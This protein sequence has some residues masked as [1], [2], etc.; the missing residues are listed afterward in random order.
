MLMVGQ[1]KDEDRNKLRQALPP[2]V[3]ATL[4]KAES[5]ERAR[6]DARYDVEPVQKDGVVTFEEAQVVLEKEKRVA[7]NLGVRRV[8]VRRVDVTTL[9]RSIRE[10][11]LETSDPRLWQAITLLQRWPSV[12]ATHELVA[13]L[14][15]AAYLHAS[16]RNVKRVLA[17]RIPPV[18]HR[19]LYV[20]SRRALTY[21]VRMLAAL[22]AVGVA[23]LTCLMRGSIGDIVAAGAADLSLRMVDE[24]CAIAAANGFAPRLPSVERIRSGVTAAGSPMSAS[25]LKDLERVGKYQG[26][27]SV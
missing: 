6:T 10:R 20:S 8:D 21:W 17:M 26:M 7:G 9:E 1:S 13:S 12:V 5:V 18:V 15:R 2:D 19:E 11:V 4:Q 25:M 27:T 22:V 23:G 16:T 14:S 3:E 24:C